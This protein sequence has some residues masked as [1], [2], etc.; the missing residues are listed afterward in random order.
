VNGAESK[1]DI[2]KKV[3]IIDDDEDALETYSA[4]LENDKTLEVLTFSSAKKAIEYITLHP[5]SS[6]L[7]IL[8]IRM[9]GMSGLRLFQAVKAISPTTTIIFLSSLD[10]APE[11]SELFSDPK[12]GNRNFLR[13]PVSRANFIE[14]VSRAMS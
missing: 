6:D 13:K 4:F 9:P 5:N 2:K 7:I 3:V 14:T 8:D 10:A 12:L 11:L 1:T